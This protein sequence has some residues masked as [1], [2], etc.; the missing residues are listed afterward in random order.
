MVLRVEFAVEWE[1]LPTM[2]VF[3]S[4]GFTGLPG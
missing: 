2:M 4:P 3:T 1:P